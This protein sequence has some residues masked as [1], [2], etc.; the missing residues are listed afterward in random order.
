MVRDRT[1]TVSV[2]MVHNVVSVGRVSLARTNEEASPSSTPPSPSQLGEGLT[3]DGCS[4]QHSTH[5]AE[6]REYAVRKLADDV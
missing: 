2:N 6:T 5:N 3:T 4:S 1:L